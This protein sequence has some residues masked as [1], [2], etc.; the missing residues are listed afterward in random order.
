M[1][2]EAAK[3]IVPAYSVDL[4]KAFECC[5]ESVRDDIRDNPYLAEAMR[6]MTVGGYR[7][8]IGCFWNAVVDD[9]RNKILYRSISLFNKEVKPRKEIK[10][11]EDFQDYVNDDELI[12]GA[13][14]IG[15]ITWEAHK[16]LKQSKE[17]R[18][19]FDGHP[20]SSDPSYIKVLA[21]ME[22]CVKYVLCVDYPPQ[23]IDID[24]YIATMNEATFSRNEVAIENALGDLP[25][26]YKNE[27]VNRLFHSYIIKE[28][29]SILKSNIEFIAPILWNVLPKEVKIQ[30]VRHLDSIISKGDAQAIENAFRFIQLVNADKYLSTVARKYR[31]Q[32][33]IE[34]L[35]ANLDN[36]S[37][38]DECIEYLDHYAPFVPQELVE[39]YV[40]AL[41]HTYI[42]TTGASYSYNRTDF[43][44]NGASLRIPRML[45]VF[46][47]NACSA[48]VN[49]ILNSEILKIRLRNPAKFRRLQ[50][51]A[52][53]VLDKAS[54]NFKEK[55][56]LNIILDEKRED[57]FFR[58]LRK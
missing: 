24:E 41:V 44:A 45:E 50:T 51:M 22:D 54:S 6:V 16:I 32:P 27:L 58:L 15:V 33:V 25:E 49:C 34:K 31:L 38:E 47:D 8:A 35:E 42:G 21:M 23:I 12:E 56:I 43:Y 30:V 28:S 46:D 3:E 14:K 19:I 11:Y 4:T 36:W 55:D 18:H 52:R 40:S 17:T 48:F 1:K 29:S 10:R 26:T 53:I 13:Y 57:E 9:L 37:V 20:K 2:S 7:S 5:L 39:R